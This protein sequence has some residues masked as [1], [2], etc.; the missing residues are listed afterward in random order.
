MLAKRILDLIEPHEK[1]WTG[2]RLKKFSTMKTR[3]LAGCIP[4]ELLNEINRL[5]GTKTYYVERA[6]RLYVK[7]MNAE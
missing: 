6:L 3:T 5:K 7:V 4:V 2:T 1:E